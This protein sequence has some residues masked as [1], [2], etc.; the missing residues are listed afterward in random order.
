MPTQ[1]S[2]VP[3][4]LI[5]DFDLVA[6]PEMMRNPQQRMMDVLVNDE[7]D[8]F[9][10]PHNGGHWIVTNYEM[11][12]EIL[13]NPELFGSF[14]IGVPANYEQR[15]RLIPLESD[16]Q[17]HPRYRR[18]LLP[19][20]APSII[21]K[22]EDKIRQRTINVLDAALQTPEIDFLWD[23][24]KPIPTGVFLEMLGLPQHMQPQ[25]FEWE[26]GFYRAE[27]VEARVDYGQKIAQYLSQAAEDHVTFPRDDVMSMLLEVEV[28]G[29]RLSRDEVD[30]ICY[31]L[32]L[33]G[34]DTVAAMLTFIANYLAHNQELYQK[35][36]SDKAF[37]DKATD[38]LLRM[39]AFINLNRICE[40]DTEFHGVTFKQGDNIVVPSFVT[41]RDA[42]T[43]P[44][45]HNFNPER[46]KVERNMHH[47]FGDGPHKCIG[48]H[49]AKLEVKIV[50]EEFAK[51]VDSFSITDE[52]KITAHGGTTMGMDNLPITW[53][54]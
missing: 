26:N 14:P 1:I 8:I 30:A 29:E 18:L 6:D 20:F 37:L 51:R 49:L 40:A 19:V 21:G 28:E 22:M 5:S 3:A 39:H 52:S 25:F 44:D 43:F 9:Y 33:A 45:P 24:A 31:L 38:E 47:A 27:T 42:S 36:K 10:T 16:P 2:D 54:A 23:I 46:S 4:N 50:L 7:R 34:V 15:P 32:F 35:I 48:M 11:G 12:H 17:S 53:K 41:D 13:S